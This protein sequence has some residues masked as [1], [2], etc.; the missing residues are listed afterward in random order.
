M[1]TNASLTDF[2]PTDI[3]VGDEVEFDFAHATLQ[4]VVVDVVPS[5]D[6]ANPSQRRLSISTTPESETT[7]AILDEDVRPV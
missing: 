4:G 3:E 5:G 1:S 6:L 2:D 7:Y